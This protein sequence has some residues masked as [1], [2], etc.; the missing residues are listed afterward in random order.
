MADAL[1]A[2]DMLSDGIGQLPSVVVTSEYVPQPSMSAARLPDLS[3]SDSN[4]LDLFQ[5]PIKGEAES[6]SV[7]RRRPEAGFRPG[8]LHVALPFSEQ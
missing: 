5:R 2:M 1:A 8:A 7:P 4:I 3:S 6:G